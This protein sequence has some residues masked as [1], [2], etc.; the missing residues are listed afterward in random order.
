MSHHFDT[1]AARHD[2]TVNL[3]DF[4]L[5]AGSPGRVAMVMTV[6][7]YEGPPPSNALNRQG[8]YRFEFDL[9]GDFTS[10]VA[11]AVHVCA[12]GD[13]DRIDVRREVRSG[14]RGESSHLLRGR[15][16]DL[17]I[18]SGGQVRAFVGPRS[19]PFAADAEGLGA[20]LHACADGVFAPSAFSGRR[21]FFQDRN[22]VAV[23]LEVPID[24]VGTGRVQAWA[25]ISL[26]GHAAPRQ[27]ARWG[28]PLITHL[29]VTD[30]EAQDR[31]NQTAPADGDE[32][33]ER[34]MRHMVTRVAR[35]AGSAGS[36]EAYADALTAR[37]CPVVLPYVLGSP[38]GFTFAGFN[39]RALTDDVMDVMLTLL[40]NTPLGDGVR[41]DVEAFDAAFP[42]LAPPVTSSDL[43]HART[44]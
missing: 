20:F 13:E 12:D 7:P 34:S 2:P 32:A 14:S 1:E 15:V 19:D 16:D 22:V 8:V 18:G 4:Y 17:L 24:L 44:R 21:N 26:E 41:P 35:L 37:L 23:V 6:N 31:Y 43:V 38:A 9:D 28:L 11:F 3:N 39:G 27:V 25:S 42:Y 36:P 5:F 30:P 29:F 33:A 10:E 40:T